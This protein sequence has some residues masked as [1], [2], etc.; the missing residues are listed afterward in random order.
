MKK[1]LDEV[2]RC[3]VC[4][5]NQGFEPWGEDVIPFIKNNIEL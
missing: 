5:L 1:N 2:Y 4:G 3:R